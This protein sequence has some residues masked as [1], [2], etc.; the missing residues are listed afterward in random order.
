MPVCQNCKKVR[1]VSEIAANSILVLRSRKS[2]IQD[3]PFL[4]CDECIGKIFEN[5]CAAACETIFESHK[6]LF[7]QV[8]FAEARKLENKVRW[9]IRIFNGR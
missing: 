8:D 2:F 5:S 3:K 6:A 7:T 9:S 4:L 1:K